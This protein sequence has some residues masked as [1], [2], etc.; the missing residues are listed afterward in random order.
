MP[1]SS[2]IRYIGATFEAAETNTLLN[3]PNLELHNVLI[4]GGFVERVKIKTVLCVVLVRPIPS[5]S[6]DLLQELALVHRIVFLSLLPQSAGVVKLDLGRIEL[7]QRVELREDD[8][9]EEVL[10]VVILSVNRPVFEF[11]C[12]FCTLLILQARSDNIFHAQDFI[13]GEVKPLLL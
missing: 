7:G 3:K 1:E 10:W 4:V 2:E 12:K 13:F 6:F 11:I 5:A 9:V 8:A